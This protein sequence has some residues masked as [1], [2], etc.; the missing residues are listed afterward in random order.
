MSSRVLIIDL[1]HLARYP[2]ITTGYFTAMLR[3]GGFHVDVPTGTTDMPRASRPTI[4]HRWS[5]EWR[6]RT[7]AIRQPWIQAVGQRTAKRNAEALAA[8]TRALAEAFARYLDTGYDAVLISTDLTSHP[9][10]VAMGQVCRDRG[11]P[12]ILGGDSF[13][14]HE[15]AQRWMDTPGLAALIGG[16]VEPNLC[17]IVHEVISKKTVKQRGIWH[18]NGQLTLE[19]PPLHNLD[20]IPFPDYSDFPWAH[21]PNAIVPI[22][23]GRGCGWGECS[24][25]SDVTSTT[26]RTFRSRSADNVMNEVGHQHAR[27]K[28]NRFVFKDI[29]L[30]SNLGMWQAIIENMPYMVPK[31][32]WIATV[33]VDAKSENSLSLD[34]LKQARA[35]G[36]VRV[37]TGIESGSQRVLDAM[38]KG[39]DLATTRRFLRSASEA[40]ISV[41]ATMMMG[42]P[43]ED[44]ADL[45]ASAAFLWEHEPYI[46]RVSLRRFEI[47]SGTRFAR[48]RE[49]TPSRFPQVTGLTVNHRITNIGHHYTP[50]E[51]RAYRR[52][53]SR[54]RAIVHRINRRPPRAAA[55]DFA[56][57]V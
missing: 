34:A 22:L 46:E 4:W 53:V 21:Y 52:A 2:S 13:H 32:T 50:T 48:Q 20:D 56:D 5:E 25:C 16:E 55:R 6:Y 45:E 7:Q 1:H 38:N 29:N 31:A 49:H 51:S 14:G 57:V 11:I 40:D 28:S 42:Y 12:M 27:H 44:A 18:Q 35:A 8:E 54:L 10:C 15:V 3:Q 23:T 33:H 24:F 43:D 36:M 19:A 26:G 47:P 39:T 9:H 30:N 17:H 37:T 41:R